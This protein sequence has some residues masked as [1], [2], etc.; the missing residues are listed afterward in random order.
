MITIKQRLNLRILLKC[1][2]IAVFASDRTVN[3]LFLPFLPW[4][5]SNIAINRTV[6]QNKLCFPE[7]ILSMSY[8]AWTCHGRTQRDMID[9]LTLVSHQ[10]MLSQHYW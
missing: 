4:N 7:N 6:Q 8:R 2:L 5:R 10:S 3:C 1:I 9:K